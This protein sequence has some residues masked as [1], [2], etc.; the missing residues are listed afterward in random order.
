ML[1]ADDTVSGGVRAKILD[2]GLAKL[3]QESDAQ[4]AAAAPPSAPAA[5]P[6]L[7][8]SVKTR[9]GVLIGTPMYMSPEQC[10]GSAQPDDKSDVYSLGIM[11]F[12][13]LYGDP[14][15]VSQSAG[16]LYAMHLFFP[17]PDLRELV[18][19]V[20]PK[21]AA[22]V[23]RMLEKKPAA[24]PSMEELL[25]ELQALPSS[26]LTDG[27][28]GARPSIAVAAAADTQ[29]EVG[30]SGLL[31]RHLAQ[32]AEK[33]TIAQLEAVSRGEGQISAAAGHGE[34]VA[35]QPQSNRRMK[36]AAGGVALAVAAAAT[37]A[38]V[39]LKHSPRPA[40]PPSGIAAA[41][42]APSAPEPPLVPS[43][44]PPA[45]SHPAVKPVKKT[46]ASAVS[47]SAKDKTVRKTANGSKT[48]KGKYD[49]N[50]W[51]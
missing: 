23:H 16:E 15:F 38:A 48:A 36:L 35:A 18:P 27:L 19:E 13:L 17:V 50:L 30:P 34:Q 9:T 4:D 31:R 39:G 33:T 25:T 5:G 51:K 32:L 43:P 40:S 26:G 8:R 29:S 42:P 45:P 14:P 22:L 1:I 6:S 47:H 28:P 49:V 3:L 44:A 7:P 24:R 10:H 2:F 37:V 46:S 21:V 12:E 41:A 11:F 20:E